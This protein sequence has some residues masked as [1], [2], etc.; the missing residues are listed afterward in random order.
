MTPIIV[1]IVNE[2]RACPSGPTIADG[3]IGA[4]MQ[5][6]ELLIGEIIRS[7]DLSMAGD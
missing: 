2:N 4:V 7:P 5:C 1:H 6:A 3:T